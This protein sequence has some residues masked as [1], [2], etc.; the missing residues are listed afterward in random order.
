V[1]VLDENLDVWQRRQLD[2]WGIH[3]RRIGEQVAP[4]G[5]TEIVG[6]VLL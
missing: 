4:K 5:A 6:P 1:I 2:S 3:F